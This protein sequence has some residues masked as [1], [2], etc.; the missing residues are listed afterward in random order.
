MSFDLADITNMATGMPP[1]YHRLTDA[2]RLLALGLLTLARDRWQWR[3][4]GEKLTDVEWDQAEAMVDQAIEELIE[5]IS[6]V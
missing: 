1:T 2:S 5:T 6:S 3:N 4:N